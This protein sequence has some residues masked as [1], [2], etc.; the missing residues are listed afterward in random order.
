[1]NEKFGT[2]VNVNP[3]PS[4]IVGTS[5]VSENTMQIESDLIVTNYTLLIRLN[6][7]YKDVIIFFL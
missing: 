5:H 6:S 4:T 2:K 1:M 7:P 3:P